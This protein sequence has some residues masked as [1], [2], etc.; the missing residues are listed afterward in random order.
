MRSIVVGGG[1]VGYNLIKSL[2]QKGH[3]VTLV[4]SNKS[5]CEVIAEDM[6]IEVIWGD[7]TDIEVLKD[8]GIE[9]ADY[10]AAVTGSDDI[11]FVICKLSKLYFKIN[12]TI[13][14]VA[15]PS[16]AM[17]YKTLGIEKTICVTDSIVKLMTH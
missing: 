10:L 11:N 1:S 16:N 17:I 7:G 8:A 5:I 3:K 14:S 15:N 6:D 4:D 13:A 9:K 2:R 12:N